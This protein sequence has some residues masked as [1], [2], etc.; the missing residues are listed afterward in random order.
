MTGIQIFFFL[1]AQPGLARMPRHSWSWRSFPLADLHTRLQSSLFLIILFFSK[2]LT[3]LAVPVKRENEEI[4]WNMFPSIAMLLFAC[5]VFKESPWPQ[6]WSQLFQGFLILQ[7][8]AVWIPLSAQ[9][10]RLFLHG[11]GD[12]D[13]TSH[14]WHYTEKT[15]KHMFYCHYSH[16]L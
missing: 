16:R 15:A 2:L 12:S 8:M 6:Q 14:L 11:H 13:T 5:V 1:I 10:I 7:Q 4:E 3:L 9:A